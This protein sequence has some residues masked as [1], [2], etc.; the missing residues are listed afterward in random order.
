MLVLIACQDG[1]QST[2]ED[3]SSTASLRP[4]KL[5][6]LGGTN[7]IGHDLVPEQAYPARLA[8]LLSEG[9]QTAKVVNAGITGETVAGAAARISWILQQRIDA[10][11]LALGEGMD[12]QQISAAQQLESWQQLLGTIRAAYPELPVYILDMSAGNA[13]AEMAT[14]WSTLEAKFEVVI[15]DT[16]WRRHLSS[17]QPLLDETG[18]A[19]LAKWLSGQ[20]Q[21]LPKLYYDQNSH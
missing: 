11:L 7:T 10:L 4:W 9:E 21:E 1:N 2:V 3:K 13:K 20:I 14:Q 5:I 12:E 8:E 6:C 17:S 18:H 16:E 15:L 19:E